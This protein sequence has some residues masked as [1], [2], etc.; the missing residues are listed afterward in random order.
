MPIELARQSVI[1]AHGARAT[2]DVCRR[3]ADDRFLVDG[4]DLTLPMRIAD[5]SVFAQ[6]FAVPARTARELLAESGVGLVEIWPGAGALTLM[7]VEYRDNPLGAYR[8]A[9]ILLP[10]YAPGERALPLFGGLDILRKRASH[11]V[12]AM[13][14]DQEFTTHAGRFLW[15]FPSFSRSSRSNSEPTRHAHASHTTTNSCSTCRCRRASVARS[16][17]ALRISPSAVVSCAR[18]RPA[19]MAEALRSGSAAGRPR[20][21]KPTRSRSRCA[22]SACPNARCVRSRCATRAQSSRC[23]G[24]PAQRAR[25]IANMNSG[26]SGWNGNSGR[27]SS[28]DNNGYSVLCLRQWR[29][30]SA[31]TT[32]MPA[33]SGSV[34]GSTRTSS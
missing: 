23:A 15:G 14:V 20:S 16:P 26:I 1:G 34:N 24:M 33:Y 28:A 21:A 31:C 2:D 22:H 12:Y 7:A 3:L 29:R 5:L 10:A 13:P 18:S 32:L 4:R 27:A 6:V 25:A 30:P 8:E 17:S 11:F 19:S 9:V